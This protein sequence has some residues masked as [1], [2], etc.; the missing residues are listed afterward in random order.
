LKLT[1]SSLQRVD[2]ENVRVIQPEGWPDILPH[3]EFYLR[4]EFCFPLKVLADQQFAG[5]GTAIIHGD[6]A[7]LAHIIVH[8][9]FRNKGIGTAITRSLLGSLKQ[10]HCQTIL[11]IATDLGQPVYT[12][13]GFINEME[14]VYFK[15]ENIS[16]PSPE[17]ISFHS[18][19]KQGISMLDKIVTGENRNHLLKDH[20]TNAKL[21]VDRNTVHG[22][23][24]PT[25]GEGLIVADNADAGLKLLTLKH[26]SINKTG[27]PFANKV[28]I[29]FLMRKG[30]P[31]QSR[32]N[33]M[34]LGKKLVWHPENVYGRIGGNMG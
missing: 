6:V 9:E 31:E 11:L 13:L 8:P 16:S 28:G 26:N 21:I 18:R 14:Y 12:K 2:L 24:L 15:G 29:D 17:I 5:I 23:Y 25:L 27:I 32:G 1:V 22:F 30:I 3:V 7:W 4:S 34:Y 10:H 33:R 20:F 19:H